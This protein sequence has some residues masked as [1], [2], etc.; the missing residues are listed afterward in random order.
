MRKKLPLILSMPHSGLITP[1][2]LKP[3]TVFPLKWIRMD[4][5]EGSREIYLP[6]KDRVLGF[7]HI[8]IARCFV[9]MNRAPDDRSAGGIVKTHACW[10]KK[11]YVETPPESVFQ[12]VIDKFYHPYHRRLSELT[13]IRG[14]RLGIDCHT[15]LA[16]APPDA[17]DPEGSDRPMICLSDRK[18]TSAPPE[19]TAS[20]AR[21]LAASFPEF[22]VQMNSPFSG[23]YIT[24]F[25]CQELPFVQ[26]E[27]SRTAD[28]SNE[29]KSR[30]FEQAL[31]SF[32][33]ETF[34]EYAEQVGQTWDEMPV[35]KCLTALSNRLIRWLRRVFRFGNHR[36]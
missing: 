10:G 14:A 34:P 19:W 36:G 24:R 29:E 4:S 11:L 5:D 23:G 8:D 18:G 22:E 20:L 13:R 12:A 15:M 2:E 25:H 3:Y 31:R 30:R 27:M 1:V 35:I 28:L 6:L 32:C 33:R 26:V 17:P 16:K 9:D 7:V 21:A